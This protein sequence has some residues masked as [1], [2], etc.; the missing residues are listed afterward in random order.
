MILTQGD[1]SSRIVGARPTLQPNTWTIFLIHYRLNTLLMSRCIS[2]LWMWTICTPISPLKL[3]LIVLGRFSK[4]S[5]TW[6]EEELFRLLEVNLT[7]NDFVF[8][9]TFGLNMKRNGFFLSLILIPKPRPNFTLNLTLSQSQS[10][11]LTLL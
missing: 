8:N 3:A 6:P 10:L 11:T 2:F 7:C 9:R 4:S 5:K 1:Q